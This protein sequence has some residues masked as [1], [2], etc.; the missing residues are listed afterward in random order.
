MSISDPKDTPNPVVG[1]HPIF[2]Q[3]N[4]VYLDL[5]KKIAK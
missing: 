2:F 3:D 4:Y 5:G 1:I